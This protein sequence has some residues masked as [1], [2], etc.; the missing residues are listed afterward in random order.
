MVEVRVAIGDVPMGGMKQAENGDAKVLFVRDP[1]GIRAFQPKCPHYGAPLQKGM[2]CGTTLY[3]P[4]HK[5]AFD[6][7]DGALLEPPAL[8][9]LKR[10]PVRVEG[11]T[12]IAATEPL[13]PTEVGK[14]MRDK[15]VVVVGTGAA[16]VS[17]VTTLRREG[18][19]GRITMVARE[20]GE[21][22][23]RPKLSK[24]FLAKKTDPSA[25]T[26]EP[27]FYAAHDIEVATVGAV[28]IEP[29]AKRVTLG[30]GATLV[31]DYLIV[32]TGS[33]AA[34]PHFEGDTL[35]NI[36]TLR[37]LHDA[38]AISDAA[39]TA[40]SLV[41]VGAG[42]IGLEAAAFLTKRG[43]KATVVAPEA[44]PLAKRFG[45]D[46]A[47]A[48]KAYHEG[49][50][51]RFIEGK[52]AAFEGGPLVASVRLEGGER[53]PADLVLIGAG[54]APETEVIQGLDKRDDGGLAV[55]TR[56]TVAPGVWLAGD[57]AAFPEHQDGAMARIEHWRLAQQ[58]GAH[59]AHAILGEDEPF[60]AAPFFWSNQ[61][62]KRLDYAGHASHWDRI[63]TRGDVAALDFISF[64]I[65]GDEAIAACAIG[66]N[67]QM[68][69]FLHLL[70]A[71]RIPDAAML[72][73][74]DL[75]K[76]V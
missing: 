26:I 65:Q 43:L 8:E 70:D 3:C 31:G 32:A 74:A 35:G 23:D 13:A 22:Y 14:T 50:G 64:Y 68:I 57:I 59:A 71:G 40:K 28:T 4:W 62:D 30:D 44:L 41:V 9:G 47:K 51:I 56:L 34:T 5:A 48:L 27:G 25:M 15:S 12:A 1:A 24:N 60:V 29:L 2:I 49:T 39:D 52:V 42:F 46:V 76:L 61:G 7:G 72:E 20:R 18:F 10:Y 6:I 45:D 69:A 21:P 66:Q 75:T 58:H 17:A 38:I 11:D 67:A 37:G 19:A 16:A 63:V 36:F 54:A 53:L 55:D 33:R 73:T